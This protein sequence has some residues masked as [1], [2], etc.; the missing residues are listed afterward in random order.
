MLKL[1]LCLR[2]VREYLDARAAAPCSKYLERMAEASRD[3]CMVMWAIPC[4]A[5]LLAVLW[6]ACLTVA[7]AARSSNEPGL[8]AEAPTFSLSV[9]VLSLANAAAALDGF[10]AAT[11]HKRGYPDVF[12]KIAVVTPKQYKDSAGG[13]L[14]QTTCCI[15]LEDFESWACTAQLPCGHMFHTE[16]IRTWFERNISCPMRCRRTLV[17]LAEPPKPF[18]HPPAA[19]TSETLPPAPPTPHWASLVIGRAE[20]SGVPSDSA[21]ANVTRPPPVPRRWES[22]AV[23]VVVVAV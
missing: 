9:S 6:S 4:S 14:G 8:F 5:L 11:C 17:Y 3:F 18:P 15:C 2:A 23:P 7:S 1:L 10:V 22:L 12:P 13:H 16:C 19:S 20:A 21:Q